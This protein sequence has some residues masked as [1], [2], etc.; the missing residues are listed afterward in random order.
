MKTLPIPNF[1]HPNKIA[2]QPWRVDYTTR[3]ADAV[4][5]REKHNIK[6]AAL[7]KPKIALMGIDY[8]NTFCLPDFELY[9]GGTTGNGAMEDCDRFIRW[10]YTNLPYITKIILSMD[11]HLTYQI[12][13][14]HTW[15]DAKGNH[16][17]PGATMISHE[18][19]K[20]R[21][22]M[23]DPKIAWTVAGGNLPYLERWALHY[24]KTLEE[25]G[26]YML[27]I[28]PFHGMLG[29]ISHALVSSV[30]EMAFFHSVARYSQTDI[31]IK[32][33]NLLSENY[34]IVGVEVNEDWMGNPVGEINTEFFEDLITYDYV[35]AGGEAGSHCFPW[36]MN[37]IL[38]KINAKDPDLAK[39]FYVVEDFI[40][41]VVIP[42]VLDFSAEQEKA[43]DGF[44][45]AGMNVVKSTDPMDTWPGIRL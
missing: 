20:N 26:R 3:A 39:K 43:L 4:A 12:F 41:P 36:T 34:S 31:Q 21:V 44:R 29:G 45:S 32:G 16:P 23:I 9:V 11:T 42:G 8:Q 40:S 14:P 33:G 28:W 30:A 6:S 27:I 35:I 22:W 17:T 24:T 15:I 38:D 2:E 18:D 19:V 13:H 25:K 37:D 7:D 1:Y 10:G 5:W